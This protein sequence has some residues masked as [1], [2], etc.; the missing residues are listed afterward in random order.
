[1]NGHTAVAV[2]PFFVLRSGHPKR[3]RLAPHGSREITPILA[4]S[5]APSQIERCTRTDFLTLARRCTGEIDSPS[6]VPLRRSN[7]LD[8]GWPLASTESST[9]GTSCVL[10]SECSRSLAA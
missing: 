8:F 10:V 4:A 6:I 5:H 3:W 1:M 2:W 7:V 9:G